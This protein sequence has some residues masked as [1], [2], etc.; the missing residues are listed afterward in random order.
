MPGNLRRYVCVWLCVVG[1]S[2]IAHA[3]VRLPQLQEYES[4]NPWRHNAKPSKIH[5]VGGS[6][7]HGINGAGSASASPRQSGVQNSPISVPAEPGGNGSNRAVAEDTP[8]DA[9]ADAQDGGG[10]GG[11]FGALAAKANNNPGGRPG[12][13][14]VDTDASDVPGLGGGVSPQN[15]D[16]HAPASARSR[17]SHHDQAHDD[18]RSEDGVRGEDRRRRPSN[19]SRERRRG[20]GRRLGGRRNSSASHD[21]ED[22]SG[23]PGGRRGRHGSSRVRGGR[24]RGGRA[25]ALRDQ[26]RAGRGRVASARRANQGKDRRAALAGRAH[27]DRVR[28]TRGQQQQEEEDDR[29]GGG[30]GRV[31]AA[32]R[33]KGQLRGAGAGG[34]DRDRDRDSSR[35]RRDSRRNRSSNVGAGRRRK[36][37]V[38]VS[39][40]PTGRRGRGSN[41]RLSVQERFDVIRQEYKPAN[42]AKDE[43]FKQLAD[44]CKALMAEQSELKS[45]LKQQQTAVSRLSDKIA[46]APVPSAASK[47]GNGSAR[48]R[49]EPR[50]RP[51]NLSQAGGA[52]PS[53]QLRRIASMSSAT[54]VSPMPSPMRRIK[55][56][57]SNIQDAPNDN[58]GAAGSRLPKFGRRAKEAAGGAAN[59]RSAKRGGSRAAARGARGGRRR[60]EDAGGGGGGGRGRGGRL[61][62]AEPLRKPRHLDVQR[63]GRDRGRG[64]GRNRASDE[65]RAAPNSARE[66]RAGGRGRGRRRGPG[67]G[68]QRQNSGNLELLDDQH[69]HRLRSRLRKHERSASIEAPTDGMDRVLDEMALEPVVS[70]KQRCVGL[71]RDVPCGCG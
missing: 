21:S 55:S 54:S 41:R 58:A 24:G 12:V 45:A 14:V 69:S 36:E 5:A 28:G 59:A 29:S 19:R 27:S 64:R 57:S 13:V 35:D 71:L 33:R 37:S 25:N 44:L 46:D 18:H 10:G 50:Q 48:R 52:S 51:S 53:R 66:P 62:A 31:V 4:A 20:S 30:G 42:T 34:S 17:H 40:L 70:G 26:G 32:G 9:V 1:T 3:S 43:A 68:A 2:G 67:K 11:G 49:G 16:G 8:G 38:D 7:V 22:A 60:A 56:T 63:G 15:D 23:G 47:R 61:A 6:I 65:G 39:P